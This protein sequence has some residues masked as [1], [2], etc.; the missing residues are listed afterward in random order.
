MNRHN[1][2][3]ADHRT[4][5]KRRE[6]V[7]R[8]GKGRF[9][10]KRMASVPLGPHTTAASLAEVMAA[11]ER[12]P[13]ELDWA[14]LAGNV[15]PVL[16]RR[17]PYPPGFPEPLR[18]LLPPGLLVGFGVDV[19]PAFIQIDSEMIGRWGIKPPDLAARALRNI[20]DS[21]RRLSPKLVERHSIADIPLR[22][23][24]SGTGIAST[25]VLLP[26]ALVRLFGPEPQ[27]FIAPIR[28]LLVSLPADVDRA[29]AAWIRDEFAAADPNSLACEGFYLR[30][31][32][33]TYEPLLASTA[34]H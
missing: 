31:G 21:V 3:A 18:V 33:L 11:M 4:R 9:T 29:E 25:F 16:Q 7:A 24:Q 19:G 32:R 13:E 12:L 1:R 34:M 28:D 14:S 5:R 8:P 23:F 15:V 17:R 26:D 10:V 22:I 20:G 27:C 2:S 6:E 30:D